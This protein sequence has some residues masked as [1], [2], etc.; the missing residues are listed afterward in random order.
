MWTEL[1]SMILTAAAASIPLAIRPLPWL[2]PLLCLAIGWG[3]GTVGVGL[4]GATSALYFWACTHPDQRR[5][6]RPLLLLAILTLVVATLLRRSGE[7]R[8]LGMTEAVWM[9]AQ[10]HFLGV[11]WSQWT[12]HQAEAQRAVLALF[13]WSA[14]KEIAPYFGVAPSLPFHLFAEAG[15]PGIFLWGAPVAILALLLRRGGV[16]PF[17]PLAGF[18][19]VF[20][21]TSIGTAA[22]QTLLTVDSDS[23]RSCN[24]AIAKF[25][26]NGSRDPSSLSVCPE[27]R[28]L[29]WISAVEG[30]EENLLRWHQTFP[31]DVMPAF[32]LGKGAAIR[33]NEP[34]ALHWFAEAAAGNP[35][36]DSNAKTL[37]DEARRI[38]AGDR[39][40]LELWKSTSADRLPTP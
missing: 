31:S 36:N 40:R 2:F 28:R 5:L 9:A 15:W 11:G 22:I 10:S 30:S 4:I 37:R 34:V 25:S 7:G 29:E 39:S 27:I 20:L 6:A 16:R 1:L 3:L 23:L 21:L 19:L 18:F 13:P 8:L 17:A 35:G 14:W 33:G 32:I 26:N 24:E 12:W 38:V